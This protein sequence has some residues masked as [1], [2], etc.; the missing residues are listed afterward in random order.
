MK[1]K[2][3]VLINI[4]TCLFV[5]INIVSAQNIEDY[6][7]PPRLIKDIS[8]QS[9][10]S[11]ES[12]EFTG[13]SSIAISRQGRMWAVWYS[14]ITPGEDHN[15]YVVVATS[16]DKGQ[17][18]TEVLIIDP[19]N[20]GPVRAFDPEIWIDP[21]ER[22][23]VFWAQ[24]TVVSGGTR[25]LLNNGTSAGVWTLI[26][27]DPEKDNPVWGDPTRLSDGVMLCKPII[28]SSGEWMMPVSN[29]ML[30][31]NTET[32]DTARAVVSIDSGKTWNIRGSVNIPKKIR[33]FDENMIVERKDGSLWMLIR[34]KYGIGES[35]SNDKGYTWSSLVPSNIKHPV[36]RFFI[37]KLSSGSFLLVKH[38]PID[39]QIGRSHLMAFISKDDGQTWS[40]GLLLDERV[41]ISYP[42]GQQSKD[43]IIYITYD[44]N[45][46]TDQNIL[47]TSFTEDDILCGSDSKILEVFKRRSVISQGGPK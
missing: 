5:F 42:D 1:R 24:A 28:L 8:S 37:S 10:Y 31:A 32:D 26:A 46:K 43:G 14:G 40:N 35:I 36:A 25:G 33:N 34:T 17:T 45:R 3:L 44:Y 6:L 41:G 4:A 30:T 23:F 39:M 7:R 15:N 27:D 11:P 16:S 47:V 21:N 22:L 20:E 29:W 12:R 13:I 18:W 2:F 9:K 38:G 19:D